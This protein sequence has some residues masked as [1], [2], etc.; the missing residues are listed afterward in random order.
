VEDRSG[1]GYVWTV[2]RGEWASK[3]SEDTTRP[4]NSQCQRQDGA[5]VADT[6]CSALPR[7]ESPERGQ[8]LSDCTYSAT[9]GAFGTCTAYANSTTE[10]T[11][12]APVTSCTRIDGVKVADSYCGGGQSRPCTITYT[13]TYGA[14]G[15]CVRTTAG[16]T[17]GTQ[18]ATITACIRSS[19]G[20][21]VSTHNCVGKTQACTVSFASCGNFVQSTY[22]SSYGGTSVSTKAAG[23]TLEARREAA[24]VKCET[25]AP[26]AGFPFLRVC[27]VYDRADA[28]STDVYAYYAKTAT[29]A[30][31]TGTVSNAE[32]L[33]YGT[34]SCSNN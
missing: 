28:K 13:P 10:G 7:P 23:A 32:G 3:C 17:A 1:C 2:S 11:Q 9:Y 15:N 34:F 18:T 27:G 33:K 21:S 26:P 8:N 24:R 14:Y 29:A 12:V 6:L 22:V 5:I 19:D 4:V 31:Q 20:A 25:D 30:Y 16:S